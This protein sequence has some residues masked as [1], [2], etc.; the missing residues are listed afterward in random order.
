VRITIPLCHHIKTN[1]IQCQSP[2]LKLS[3]YC[4][5][6]ERLHERHQ[7]FRS[8]KTTARGLHRGYNIQLQALE[9]A[10]SIQL[11]LSQV[12]S[13]LASGKL[14]CERASALLYG[15][16]L[17]SSNLRNLTSSPKPEEVVR[18]IS[19]TLDILNLAGELREARVTQN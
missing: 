7:N 18:S 8:T 10:E 2:S 1:G 14:S 13:A 11:A 5:F 12:M 17:A 3:S 6:H 4:F 15:L 9:D 19:T 16:Q